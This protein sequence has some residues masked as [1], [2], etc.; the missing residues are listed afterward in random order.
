M[1][2]QQALTELYYDG[3]C[4]LCKRAV[5]WLS[6]QDAKSRRLAFF[7][8]T[9]P[10]SL[11][12]LK[13]LVGEIPNVS[14]AMWAVRNR[15]LYEGYDAFRVALVQL[16]QIRLLGSLMAFPLVRF[17]GMLI[18]RFVALNRHKLGCSIRK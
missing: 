7:D 9:K 16:P 18:Y 3:E 6:I 1:V 11:L 5:E 8:A 2:N 4:R 14:R 13:G 12:R 10:E 15:E 17:P